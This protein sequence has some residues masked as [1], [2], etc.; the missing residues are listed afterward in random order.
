MDPLSDI[1]HLLRPHAVFSKPIEGRGP[2]G[3]RYAAYGLPGFSIVLEGRCWLS[4]DEARPVLLDRGDLVLL[5][6]SPAFVLASGPD[7]ECVPGVPS[8]EGVRHGD[9]EGEPD[10]RMLGGSFRIDPVNAPALLPL[11]PRMIHIRSAEGDTGR[12]ALL[13]S[14]S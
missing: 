6:S 3:V 13:S 14:A 10:F 1:I 9:P 2:W 12:L 7:A 8:Q 5:P 4:L 11:L